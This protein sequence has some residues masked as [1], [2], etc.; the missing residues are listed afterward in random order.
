V[1]AQVG[2]RQKVLSLA[3]EVRVA[4]ES[5]YL[6]LGVNRFG[7]QAAPAELV[8]EVDRK[9]LGS[10]LEVPERRSTL[11]PDP[12][13]VSLEEYLG[14][15][16]T[17]EITQLP[18]G[19]KSSIQWRTAAL[20]GHWPGLLPIFEDQ[21]EL[22]EQLG[23]GGATVQLDPQNK[24]SGTASLKILPAEGGDP[25]RL[26]LRVEICETPKLGE[27]RYLRFAWKK[28]GSGPVCVSLGHDDRW[29]PDDLADASRRSFRYDAGGGLP[30]FQA[31][32]RL[33]TKLPEEWVVVTRDL[34][35]DFGSFTLTGISLS[36]PSG[37]PAWFDQ[38]YLAR[39]P[40]DFQRLPAGK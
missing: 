34:Y 2:P 20:V 40:G 27:F 9:Q 5:R 14:Q 1:I 4:P 17:I 37:D 26:D 36:T 6:L 3:R 7:P 32:V 19:P 38:L 28:R 31:A 10:T 25:H 35:A 11:E 23:R 29:G 39:T 24:H 30:S 13:M 15:S 21:A 33:S 12:L 8:V 22:A 18:L 16:V